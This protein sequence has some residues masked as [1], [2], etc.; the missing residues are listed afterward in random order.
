MEEDIVHFEHL[1]V[2]IRCLRMLVFVVIVVVV[3]MIDE[4][5]FESVSCLLYILSFYH[6]TVGKSTHESIISNTIKER[7]FPKFRI[8]DETAASRENSPHQIEISI[9]GGMTKTM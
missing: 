3:L 5:S 4:V 2:F 1:N 7:T 9:A 6:A 8:T